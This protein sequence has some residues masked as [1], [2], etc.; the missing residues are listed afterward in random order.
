[1][2]P[3]LARKN[4]ET[5][6]DEREISFLTNS[7]EQYRLCRVNR[8]LNVEKLPEIKT[9]EIDIFDKNILNEKK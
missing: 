3:C 9:F 1:M 8:F 6:K 2:D 5:K 7:E 4:Q